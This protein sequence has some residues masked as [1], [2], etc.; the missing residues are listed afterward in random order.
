MGKKTEKLWFVKVC[1]VSRTPRTCHFYELMWG[2]WDGEVDWG[3]PL[4]HCTAISQ[5]VVY[6]QFFMH[7]HILA[8]YEPWT[9]LICHEFWFV[10]Q[11]MPI[12]IHELTTEQIGTYFII[13]TIALYMIHWAISTFVHRKQPNVSQR[14]INWEGLATLFF[15]CPVVVR[16]IEESFLLSSWSWPY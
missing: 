8:F 14:G 12:P 7:G 15:T 3:H 9:D 5:L 13:N 16:R 4:P 10:S 2:S 1:G 6:C 11:F